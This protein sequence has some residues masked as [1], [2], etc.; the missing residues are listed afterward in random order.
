M[1]T[2][3]LKKYWLSIAVSLFLIS[4]NGCRAISKEALIADIDTYQQDSIFLNGEEIPILY[5]PNFFSGTEDSYRQFIDSFFRRYKNSRYLV[6]D[7]R[8]NRGG[9]GYRGFYLLDYF[10]DSPYPIAN[11]F[12]FKVSQKMRNSIYASKAGSQLRH[13]KNGEYLD[14]TE[15]RTWTPHQTS[16][17]FTGK[18]FLIISESTFSAGVVFAAVFKANHM[19]IV[20]GRE[21][22]SRVRF[23][24]DSVTVKLPNSGLK[25]RIPVAVYELPG[26]NPD[27]GVVPDIVVVNTISHYRSGRDMDMEKV[28][29]LIQM[30]IAE[31]PN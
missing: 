14:V 5:L 2:G 16:M 17:K 18:V 12:V 25:C 22:A 30:D 3:F 1:I 8:N 19:G 10:T 9:S 24:S 7:L 20:I 15:H 29:E 21:T 11:Q 4:M 6:I 13:V 27:R 23:C 26:T 31:Q 28:K